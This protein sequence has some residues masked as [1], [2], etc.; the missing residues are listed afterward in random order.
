MRNEGVR[1]R[2]ELER[3]LSKGGSE[4]TELVWA[5]GKNG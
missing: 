3:K 4:S 2:I 5:Y 1:Q